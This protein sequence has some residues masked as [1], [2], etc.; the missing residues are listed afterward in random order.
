MAQLDEM[1]HAILSD[2]GSM[3]QIMQLAQQFSGSQATPFPQE[4][5]P[6]QPETPQIPTNTSTPSGGFDSG[7]IGKLLPLLQEYSRSDSNTMQLLLALQPFLKPEKQDK[8]QRAAKLARLIHLG[9]RVLT[10]WEV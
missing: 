9:K 6:P 2:P 10:E 7:W 1:F 8:I 5:V 4:D 3:A